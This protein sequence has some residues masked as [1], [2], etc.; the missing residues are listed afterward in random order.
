M[1]TAWPAFSSPSHPDAL[2]RLRVCADVVLF[3]PREAAEG[4]ARVKR[5]EDGEQFDVP[6]SE[7]SAWFALQSGAEAPAIAPPAAAPAEAAAA[8]A[9]GDARG[10]QI[11]ALLARVRSLD[12]DVIDGFVSSSAKLMDSLEQVRGK[13]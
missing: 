2:A 10:E 8:A 3:A 6:I 4:L 11:D 9:G 13:P 5:M 1:A 12:S 7:L